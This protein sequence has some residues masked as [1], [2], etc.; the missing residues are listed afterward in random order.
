MANLGPTIKFGLLLLPVNATGFSNGIAAFDITN[1][2]DP[3]NPSSYSYRAETFQGRLPTVR[4][5]L[6]E[7]VDL[8]QATLSISLTG[9]MGFEAG[10]T[11][12]QVAAGPVS[13]NIG[14]AGATGIVMTAACDITLTA[15]NPQLSWSRAA[16]GGPI[17][18]V[19]MT[20]IGTVEEVSL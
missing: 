19:S 16:N 12:Q 10:E 9:S 4:R 20:M 15:Y 6:V 18:I 3:N 17:A 11:I 7:Y 8:G 13:I 2:N 5:V 1:F 14:T